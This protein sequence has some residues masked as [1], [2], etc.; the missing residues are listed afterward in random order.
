MAEDKELKEIWAE[1]DRQRKIN[2]SQTALIQKLLK[3]SIHTLLWL[4]VL[5]TTMFTQK[6][7]DQLLQKD[8]EQILTTVESCLKLVSGAGL[9]YPVGRVGI[10]THN[11]FKAEDAEISAS[12]DEENTGGST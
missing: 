10:T 11:Q 9:V 7:F 3:H 4:G 1:L 5:T 8:W 12:L 2:Q 6:Q